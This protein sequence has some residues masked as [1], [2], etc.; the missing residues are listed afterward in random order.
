MKRFITLALLLCSIGCRGP[1]AVPAFRRLDAEE[2]A[3]VDQI[4]NNVLEKPNRLDRE[5]L[6]DVMLA[7][8]LHASGVDKASYHAEKD[9]AQGKVVMDVQFDRS[10]PLEDWFLLEVRDQ[11]GNVLRKEHYSG[12]EVWSHADDLTGL[13]LRATLRET[14]APASTTQPTTEP[15]A[16]TQPTTLPSEAELRR[17]YLQIRYQQIMAA[18]QPMGH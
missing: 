3:Q 18:T 4:W 7:Y 12:D 13:D 1:L 15:I 6:L 2:Q 17:Q 5:L 8:Q 9:Y 11:K 14:A 16:T 10:K